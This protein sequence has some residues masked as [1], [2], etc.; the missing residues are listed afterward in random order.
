M[1]SGHLGAR[2][3]HEPGSET[4]RR[5]APARA[6][7]RRTWRWSPRRCSPRWSGGRSWCTCRRARLAWDRTRVRADAGSFTLRS[8]QTALADNTLFQQVLRGVL[9]TWA[10]DL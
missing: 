3:P 8:S 6:C 9:L 2:A 10:E 1:A 4:C 7:P 5:A